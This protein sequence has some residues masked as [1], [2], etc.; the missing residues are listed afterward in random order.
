MP[1]LKFER[2]GRSAGG[3]PSLH[4]ALAR[5]HRDERG[6]DGVNKILIIAMIVVP[7]VIVLIHFGNEIVDFFQQMWGRLMG[8][9]EYKSPELGYPGGTG[10]GTGGMPGP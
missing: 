1:R 5:L 10:G 3:A 4:G 2:L 8:T 6:D 7:L 9:S